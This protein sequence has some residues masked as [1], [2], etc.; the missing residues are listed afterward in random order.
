[1]RRSVVATGLAALFSGTALL[2]NIVF[3]FSLPIGLVSAAVVLGGVLAL[4]IVKANLTERRHSAGVARAGIFAGLAATIVYDLTRAVLG[5]LDPSP[6]DP[7]GAIRIFGTLLVGPSVPVA[8]IMI[9]GIVLHMVNGMCFGLSYAALFGRDGQCTTSSAVVTG[10]SWGLFLELFQATLYPEWL[11]IAAL[12]EFLLISAL[13]HVAFGL[14][15]GLFSRRY[16]RKWAFDPY[17]IG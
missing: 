15:L 2:A 13:S 4:T 16:L 14:S 11:R 1:M 5:Q 9:S 3:G 7:F 12:S 10:V 17:W 8:A 6:F